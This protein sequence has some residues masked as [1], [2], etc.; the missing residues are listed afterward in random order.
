[1]GIYTFCPECE[2]KVK[3]GINRYEMESN[4]EKIL[5]FLYCGKCDLTLNLFRWVKVTVVKFEDEEY[6]KEDTSFWEIVLGKLPIKVLFWLNSIRR[7]MTGEYGV[8]D[9]TLVM[10]V[11]EIIDSV[12][13]Q[14][15]EMSGEKYSGDYDEFDQFMDRSL[16]VICETGE[17]VH[18]Q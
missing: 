1:M 8:P 13:T 4:S 10:D 18:V 12:V 7:W 9:P 15:E 11:P 16:K 5:Y 2:E 6:A 14:V 17:Q 3:A